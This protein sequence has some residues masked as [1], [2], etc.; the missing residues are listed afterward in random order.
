MAVETK[1]IDA[2]EKPK[3]VNSVPF[4]RLFSFTDPVDRVL[5]FLG[6]VAAVGHG[7]SMPL[8]TVILG[9]VVN[10]FGMTNNPGGVAHSV[11]RVAL[12]FL[13]LAVGSGASA[14]IQVACWM[15]TGERQAA[16]IRGLYLKTLL[17]Q[18]IGF[19]DKET[20]TGQVIGGMSADTIVIQEAMGEKVGK[21]VQLVAMFLGGFTVAL[22]KG[23]QLTLV[24]LSSFPA[25][26]IAGAILGITIEK[27]ASRAEN[28]YAVA[29]TIIQQTIGAIRTVGSFTGE[30]RAIAKY[31]ESML[32]ASRAYVRGGLASGLGYGSMMCIVYCSFALALWF[33]GKMVL[34]KGYSGG[35]VVSVIFAII[36]GSLSLGEA[37]PCIAAFVSGQAA[38]FKLF[39]VIERKP[40]IDAYLKDGKTLDEIRGEIE[41]KDIDFSYP[42]RPHEKIF[43]GFSLCIPSGSTVALVGGSGSGKSTVISLIERFY[44]PDAGQV[45][46]DGINLKEFQLKWIRQK[47]SL[48]SQEPVLFAT[49]IREN[50]LYGKDGAT[51]DEIRAAAE[52]ANAAKFIDKLPE[53][54]DT[55]VGEH[56]ALLSGGQ[57]QRIAI[58]RAIL[59]DPKILLLD[60]ATSALDTE[61]ERKV[62]VALD[63]FLVD[64]TTVVVAHRLS[65]VKNADTIAVIDHGRIIEK[66]THSELTQDPNGA[67]SQLIRLQ[68]TSD[69]SD[70]KEFSDS[71][72]PRMLLD[73][74]L[75]AVHSPFRPFPR[76]NIS[77]KSANEGDDDI[78]SLKSARESS[79]SSLW[80]VASLA[81]SEAPV[82][83]LGSV[84]AAGVG[85]ILPILGYLLSSM[86]KT[87]YETPHDLRKHSRYLACLLVALGVLSLLLQP[88]RTYYFCVAA[89][90]LV[91]RARKTCFEKVVHMEIS[92]FDEVEHSSSAVCMM[93]SEDASAVQTAVADG[94]SLII[95][96][97]ASAIGGAVIALMLSWRIALIF[98]TLIP[99]LGASNYTEIKL[100]KGF[101][102]HTKK[103]YAEASQV[104]NEAVGS[105]RTVAS[106]CAEAKVMELY[107]KKCEGPIKMGSRQGIITGIGLGLSMFLL[108]S[109]YGASFYSGA[110]LVDHGK[111]TFPDVLHVFFV[112]TLSCMAIASTSSLIP[113][114]AKARRAATSIFE[115]LDTKSKIDSSDESGGIIQNLKGDIVFRHVSFKYSLRPDVQIFGD[116]CLTVHSGK[117]VALVGESGCGK[118]TVISLL[119]RYY[120]PDTGRILIDGS[121]IQTLQL[122]WLRQQMG[123]VSQEPV[124]FNDTIYANIA[125]GK[126][127]DVSEA[128]IIS[129][130]ESANAHNFISS[131]AQGYDTMVGDGG[132]QLSGGQKQRVAIARAIIKSPKILLLDEAT[133]ALDAES[134]RAVQDALDKAMVDRTTVV[135]A[136]RLSTIK[137]VDLIAVLKN[138]GVA[139]MGS[140]ESLLNRETSIYASLVRLQSGIESK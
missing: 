133:S 4:Y 42:A 5:M 134:E 34:E 19:F 6:S 92:W 91:G 94:L 125:Y 93:L 71:G 130:S 120:D 111:S 36:M 87:F 83:I 80:R 119:Q 2:A 109:V 128:E 49:T 32:K 39:E 131:L 126:E 88:M 106:F 35:D 69:G 29:S 31:E 103:L 24:L 9:E 12:K 17:R 89:A 138:G 50:L 114:I 7:L 22:I 85:L 56:G 21:F 45:L 72:E 61:S 59:K 68:A 47:I 117:T 52:L 16:R 108:Y 10:T 129:A 60:E 98:L 54:L 55:L 64:R 48:V 82:L 57:K 81:G 3:V 73:H 33:G 14:C 132:I 13:Y 62:Q 105:I 74:R 26:V 58:A 136:H 46:I 113:D 37:S 79:N 30:K 44:D 101:T 43:S 118:S 124:L 84:A 40:R 28:A 121:D 66:G 77:Q 107:T 51:T 123:L 127:G 63:S 99:F 65:T 137:G 122:K 115:M 104:A 102:D 97:A 78:S 135:V 38:A 96:N 139:E 112:L 11:S 70:E 20:N 18:E 15:I 116:L 76:S 75:S 140:H 23:W 90:K 8:M 53:G 95:Q 110:L 1:G 86:I 41:L 100:M 67:Y 25:I 27:A